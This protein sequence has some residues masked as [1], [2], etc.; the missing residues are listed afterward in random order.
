MPEVTLTS[1]L[2]KVGKINAISIEK[3][4]VLLWKLYLIAKYPKHLSNIFGDRI[5]KWEKIIN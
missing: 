3:Y 4:S 2:D 5:I 1:S